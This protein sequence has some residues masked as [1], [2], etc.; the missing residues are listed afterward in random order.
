MRIAR[1]LAV[2]LALVVLAA[3]GGGGN[4]SGDGGADYSPTEPS[5]GGTTTTPPSTSSDIRVTDNAFTPSAT[6]VAPGS[7]VTWT[8]AAAA[9][10]DVTFTDGP[11]SPIQVSGTYQRTFA[12]AGSF[13]YRCS[14][15]G[16]AMS[17]TI[18]VR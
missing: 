7:T 13:P 11:R 9:E 15:H 5:G 10:H 3:C 18:T 14:I 1:A 2:P 12:A 4:G 16:A 17:G 6:T 8:W